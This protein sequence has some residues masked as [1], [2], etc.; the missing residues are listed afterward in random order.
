[1]D[2]VLQFGT[3]RFL[4]GFVEAFIDD[5]ER[6]RDA[7]GQP[8]ARRVTVVE[9]TG[10]GMAGRLAA[11]DHVYELHTRGLDDGVVVDT[12]RSIRVIDRSVDASEQMHEVTEVALG[13]DLTMIVSN[14]TEQGYAPG[15]FPRLLA[16]VLAARARARMPG[17][18]ILPCELIDRNGDRL[19]RLVSDELVRAEEDPA[20]VA[21]VDDTNTWATTMVDR[22]VT[23]SARGPSDA[24]GGLGV[25]VE[26]FA[27]WVVELPEDVQP[28]EHPCVT[29]TADVTP[30]VLRKIRILNG[31]HTALVARTRGSS[32]AF[33]RE[34]VEDPDIIEWLE[35]LLRE[36][37]VPALADRVVN[38][39]GFVTS[40][41]ERLRNPFIDHHLADIEA[42]HRQKL[43]LRLLPS[44]ED[45]LRLFGHPPRRL[46]EILE[47]EGVLT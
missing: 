26:P 1:M 10:S 15:R 32:Y 39:Q 30:F 12:S 27:S 22:I 16:T 9:T 7:A 29:R 36:E 4:R 2:R 31:A 37:I 23:A 34:A 44:Y 11:Q 17:L 43:S 14:T 8:P 13:A 46:T 33:V 47:Q 18:V 21:M 42:N 24:A 28:L 20:I 35:E 25:V 19:R 45:H 5:A 40:V 41:L 3:G 38:G 6:S